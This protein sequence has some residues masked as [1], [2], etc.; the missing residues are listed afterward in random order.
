M[1]DA[2]KSVT[3]SGVATLATSLTGPMVD[4]AIALLP[5]DLVPEYLVRVEEAKSLLSVF[6]KGLEARLIEAGKTGA[7]FEIGGQTYGF[8]GA[9]RTDWTALDR[10]IPFLVSS[11]VRLE[12]VAAAV[13][14]ARVTDLRAAVSEIKDEEKR[15]ELL[16]EIENA[17]AKKG[18]RGAPHLV[19]K[20]YAVSAKGKDK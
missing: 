16:E 17:R 6:Q 13:S 8:F 15:K 5:I 19:L 9:Q 18:D 2:E 14:N 20:Q 12:A 10:L 4:Q 1:T 3:P 7:D 11:G